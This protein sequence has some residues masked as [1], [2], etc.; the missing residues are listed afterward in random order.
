SGVTDYIASWNNDD[1]AGAIVVEYSGLGSY[2]PAVFSGHDN[3]YNGGASWTSGTGGTL[4]NSGDLLFCFAVDGR[5]SSQTWTQSGSFTTVLNANDSNTGALHLAQ[6]TN[7]GTTTGQACSGT[8]GS[9]GSQEI[10]AIIGGYLPVGAPGPPVANSQSVTSNG[11]PVAITL[12]ATDS[13]GD[14]LTYSIVTEPAN[15]T[16]SGTAPNVTYT[17][18]TG[19]SGTDSFTFQAHDGQLNSNTATVTIQV[20]PPGTG[21]TKIGQA[22][23]ACSGGSCTALSVAYAPTAGNSALV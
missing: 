7:P 1:N 3:G 5:D 21:I 20:V 14:P 17:P 13:D 22:T 8:I 11:S 19:F 18:T 9:T 10:L 12:T 6:W 2:D 16:L 15:G 4:S 23:N